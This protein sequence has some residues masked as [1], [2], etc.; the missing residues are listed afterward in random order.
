M[1]VS[2]KKPDFILL[3]ETMY[4]GDKT[5]EFCRPSSRTCLL[6]LL[7]QLASLGGLLSTR[8]PKLTALNSSTFPF[9]IVEDLKDPCSLRIII[10]YGPYAYRSRIGTTLPTTCFFLCVNSELEGTRTSH[11]L[12]RRSGV[13]A[14]GLIPKKDFSPTG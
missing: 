9:V 5:L 3:Q 8:S 12:L 13:I 2:S 6:V 14:Q 10:V 7:T 4:N 11:F 1:L